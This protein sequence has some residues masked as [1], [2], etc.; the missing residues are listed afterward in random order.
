MGLS[1]LDTARVNQSGLREDRRR[2]ILRCAKQIFSKKGFHNAS[3]SDIIQQAGIARG[4]FYLYF[5]SKRDV[6]DRLLDDLLQELRLRIQPIN[7]APGNPQPLDQLKANI[8]R[9][10]ELVLQE[11]ELFQILLHYAS[12]LDQQSAAI[13]RTFYDRVLTLIELSLQHGK[14]LGLVR[15][16]DERIMAVCILGTIKEVADWLTAQRRK[17][18]ALDVVAE[19]MVGFGLWGLFSGRRE[20]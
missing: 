8:H 13:L 1:F 6:F 18:T 20:T 14:R 17:P 10:L 11:P 19:E 5:T 4:T 2:Q 16:C 9:V 3:V 15:A 7:L 12:G